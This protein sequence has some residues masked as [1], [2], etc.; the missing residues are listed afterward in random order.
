M[1][2]N[3]LIIQNSGQEVQQN[4]VTQLGVTGG[5]ADDHVLAEILR[6]QPYN[7]STYAKAIVPAGYP[8]MT[9]VGTVVPT[10][11]AN[12]SVS[13]NPFRAIIGT[14]NAVNATPPTGDITT[15][16]NAL[17]NYR[18]IRSG[19]FVGT[20]GSALAQPIALTP[21]AG[22][23]PRWDLIYAVVT[24]DT[25]GPSVSRR[26]KDPVT[27][28]ITVLNV[29]QYIFTSVAVAVVTGVAAASPL[30]PG[31]PADG[32]GSF[33]IPLAYVRITTTFG[34]TTIL[35]TQDIRSTIGV[36]PDALSF[37]DLKGAGIRPASGNNDGNVNFNAGGTFA[38]NPATAGTRPGPWMPP[39]WVGSARL[40]AQVDNITNSSASWSH[41]NTAVV[42]SSI[43]WRGRYFKITVGAY[44]NGQAGFFGTDPS[45][46]ATS[47]APYPLLGATTIYTVLSNSMG[48]DG[49]LVSGASTVFFAGQSVLANMASASGGIGL[50]VDPSTGSLRWFTS[51]VPLCRFVLWIE[52]SAQM[53]NA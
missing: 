6:L 31:P 3:A 37:V 23:H 16:P 47:C 24:P 18:D 51:T 33:N 50:Y 21:S 8:G 29:P 38:W 44:L 11:S 5:L 39:D 36:G 13:I 45:G 17:A 30:L 52:A 48:I 42:D 12:G 49:S 28:N 27:G 9:G 40:L 41:V 20:T 53:P 25:S 22:V 15:D 46:V 10:G 2:E 14:R 26:V 19:I 7:G 35:F 34:S 1:A 43:D 4:D 32:S